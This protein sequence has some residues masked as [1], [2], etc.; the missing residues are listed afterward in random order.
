MTN[1]VFK[2]ALSGLQKFTGIGG[3]RKK[4]SKKSKSSKL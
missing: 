1:D 3:K 2:T 4:C